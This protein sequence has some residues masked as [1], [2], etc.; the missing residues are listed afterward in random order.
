MHEG[1]YLI[2]IGSVSYFV[3]WFVFGEKMGYPLGAH[4]NQAKEVPHE[5]E[6]SHKE[7]ATGV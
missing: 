7:F 2:E 3:S 1:K 5:T 6:I 4:T